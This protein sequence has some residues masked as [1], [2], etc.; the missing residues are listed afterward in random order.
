[1]KLWIL[2]L[3]GMNLFTFALMGYDKGRARRKERRVPE[4][5]LFGYSAL[6]GALGAWLGMWVWRHKTKH[7]SFVI[8]IP[9]LLVL[10]GVMAYFVW[11][12]IGYIT[13]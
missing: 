3:V 11:K 7:P 9:G 8:G 5:R 13:G 12:G 10:N 1:M 6:G 2:Y 4:K